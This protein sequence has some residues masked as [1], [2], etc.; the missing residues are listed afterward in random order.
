VDRMLMELAVADN[1]PDKRG[2]RVPTRRS[3]NH[4][5]S[6]SNSLQS[7]SFPDSARR[8]ELE[9]NGLGGG[10]EMSS[11]NQT[12]YDNAESVNSDLE[13]ARSDSEMAIST[14]KLE[15]LKRALRPTLASLNAYR[16]NRLPPLL[17]FGQ[18]TKQNMT[19]MRPP[20]PSPNTALVT[21]ISG[22]TP[23]FPPLVG[24]PF[25]AG[26][27]ADI[28]SSN[29]SSLASSRM[30]FAVSRPRWKQSIHSIGYDNEYEL[31][32]VATSQN[33][34]M[35]SGMH[36]NGVLPSDGR[37]MTQRGGDTDFIPM[38]ADINDGEGMLD[39]R[40]QVEK[41]S[42]DIQRNFGEFQLATF[43]DIDKSE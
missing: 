31:A 17:P 30:N 37:D 3:K 23:K 43:S 34:S 9:K 4:S 36:F 10:R 40:G 16:Q 42:R 5:L 12:D 19:Q 2:G 33:S 6:A 35:A 32:S 11:A 25:D 20:D 39:A 26:N 15:E 21:Q 29:C 38:D 8:L 24:R 27:E 28:E 14:S 13:E 18:I 41:L 7:L 22:P 1:Y